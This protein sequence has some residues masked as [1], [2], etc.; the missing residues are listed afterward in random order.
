MCPI[1]YLIGLGQLPFI[2]G[3]SGAHPI[4]G[5]PLKKMVDLHIG[6]NRGE[7]HSDR[8]YLKLAGLYLW[9]NGDWKEGL[10]GKPEKRQEKTRNPYHPCNVSYNAH[11]LLPWMG[12]TLM[13]IWV[14]YAC[15]PGSHCHHF[16]LK[17]NMVP[18]F[19]MIT[20][21]CIYETTIYLFRLTIS[22]SPWMPTSK[23]GGLSSN[24]Y[25]E[26]CPKPLY[27]L[28]IFLGS[29]EPCEFKT[30]IYWGLP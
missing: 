17:Y 6:P 4:T 24:I 10:P 13:N 23:V 12:L 28:Y 16:F 14:T 25:L 1:L 22:G 3:F 2:T 9:W 27:N 21:P 26:G 7:F 29:P 19:W 11:L 20:N 30:N 5:I 15:I 8:W 18:L